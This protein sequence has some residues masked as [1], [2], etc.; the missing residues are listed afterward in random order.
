LSDASKRGAGEK[1][2]FS[3][4]RENGE[5]KFSVSGTV[6][7]SEGEVVFVSLSTEDRFSNFKNRPLPPEPYTQVIE[8]LPH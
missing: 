4:S 5:E 3:K 7:S 6:I 8:L 2:S 1:D